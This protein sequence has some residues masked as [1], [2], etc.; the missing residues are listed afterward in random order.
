M[1][2]Q[3]V[4]ESGSPLAATD[5]AGNIVWKENYRP[6]GERLTN[7]AESAD[8]RQWFHGKA[9]DADTGLSYFGARY[10]DPVLGRFMGVDP[11]GFQE[12]NIHSFNK[13]AYGNNNPYRYIDPDGRMPVL[14]YALYV[15]SVRGSIWLAQRQAGAIMAAEIGAGVAT[16]AV[17]PSVAFESAAVKVAKE[18]TLSRSL[19][20]EAATHAA[21][22]IR[23]G[24][25]DVLTIERSGAAANRAASTGGLKKIPGKQLDEYPPAMFKE[26]GSGASVRAINGRDNMSAGACIGNSCRGLPDGAK[27]KINIGD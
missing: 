4:N 27:V 26:G 15:A 7:Q 10:Y 9:A 24:M 12:D 23:A 13:Y 8:N 20:G 19:H 25:P 17:V 16:G 6:F 2:E 3:K 14:V 22:A 21:D 1:S 5:A 11:V 18:I